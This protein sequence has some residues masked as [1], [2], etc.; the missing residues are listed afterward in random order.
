MHLA[1]S[2]KEN[3]ATY[4]GLQKV[5][6]R[7]FVVRIMEDQKVQVGDVI[8]HSQHENQNYFYHYIVVGIID[9]TVIVHRTIINKNRRLE[10]SD[11]STFK[12]C[13][14]KISW[15]PYGWKFL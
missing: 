3:L 4:K 2:T 14:N 13:L 9:D 8:C 10:N 15:T 11:F 1:K 12:G 7:P 5:I 6:W